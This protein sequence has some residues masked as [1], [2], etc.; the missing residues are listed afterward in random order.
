MYVLM[1]TET[2]VLC[3]FQ[4]L[5]LKLFYLMFLIFG[6]YFFIPHKSFVHLENFLALFNITQIFFL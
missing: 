1:Y 4:V 3:V 6:E 5:L 2:Y